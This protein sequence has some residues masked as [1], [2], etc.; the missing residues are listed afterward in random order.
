MGIA[1]ES[2]NLIIPIRVIESKYPGGWVQCREDHGLKASPSHFG[3]CWH[4]GELFRDGAMNAFDFEMLVDRWKALGL[5]ATKRRQGKAVAGDYCLYSR[6]SASP[7]HPCQW[8]QIDKEQGI[9][10]FVPDGDTQVSKQ[11]KSSRG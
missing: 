5:K 3:A 8:L 2:L 1:L 4:D 11:E 10:T 9:A 6:F 7:V